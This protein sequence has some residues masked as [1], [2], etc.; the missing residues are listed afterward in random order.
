[1]FDTE[2]I[3]NEELQAKFASC[4]LKPYQECG[5]EVPLLL[6]KYQICKNI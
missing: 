2:Y 4:E 3:D 1:D 6:E 5:E